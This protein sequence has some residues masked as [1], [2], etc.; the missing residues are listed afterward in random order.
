M[1]IKNYP[2]F[3]NSVSTHDGIPALE[4][5]LSLF[6]FNLFFFSVVGLCVCLTGC[7]ALRPL[8]NR[9]L[10]YLGRISYGLY[11]YHNLI[12]ALAQKATG[13]L[14][15]SLPTT[16]IALAATLAI[17]SLSWALVERPLLALKDRFPYRRDSERLLPPTAPPLCPP[18]RPAP[19]RAP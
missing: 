2:I 4:S 6:G 15:L 13:S 11:L 1:S 18:P 7:G 17:A 19:H 12:L 16:L 3:A 8:R 14:E 9:A 5:S 10:G